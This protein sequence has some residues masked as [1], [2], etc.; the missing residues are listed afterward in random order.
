M[1]RTLVIGVGNPLRGDDAAGL[2]VARRLAARG[3]EGVHEASG[4][5]ASLMGLWQGAACVLLADAARSGADPG[6]VTRL[7]ASSQALPAAF[8]HCST[9]AFGVA[10]A[11]ELARSLGS[12][13][14]RILIF[15]IEGVSF[16]HG[17]PLSPAVETGVRKA[18]EMIETEMNE[19]LLAKK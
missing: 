17:A 9:H 19:F 8:L 14:P 13:P 3:V 10:E 11:V 1:S 7:D 16:E 6:T 2:H 5:T 4:E 12:L 18:V 15:G